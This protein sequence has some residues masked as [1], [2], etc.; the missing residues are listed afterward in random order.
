MLGLTFQQEGD[1]F[2]AN[3]A[4]LFGQRWRFC[5]IIIK[6]S[7]QLDLVKWWRERST[8]AKWLK[9]ESSRCGGEFCAVLAFFSWT[10]VG[11]EVTSF[12]RGPMEHHIFPRVLF[13][14]ELKSQQQKL[15]RFQVS[16]LESCVLIRHPVPLA[17]QLGTSTE[18]RA[19]IKKGCLY[20]D[21]LASFFLHDQLSKRHLSL[22]KNEFIICTV[23]SL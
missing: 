18:V 4:D 19:W 6:I 21:C 14:F 22:R 16:Q 15:M 3:H 23:P 17:S 7:T 8:V 11:L 10:S 12:G 1:S 5:S 13:S 20:C 9:T 2:C